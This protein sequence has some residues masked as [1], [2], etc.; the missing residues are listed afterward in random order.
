MVVH[1]YSICKSYLVSSGGVRGSK[2]FMPNK[3]STTDKRKPLY[4]VIRHLLHNWFLSNAV[5]TIYFQ[6]GLSIACMV[7]KV[8]RTFDDQN[9][10]SFK[11]KMDN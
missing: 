7:L 6:I 4:R 1:L 2:L 5:R 10:S 3:T 9:D 11:T 8:A